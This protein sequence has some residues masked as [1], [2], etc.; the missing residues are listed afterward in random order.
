M[1]AL[2]HFVSIIFHP[3]LL[4]TY[5][6]WVLGWFFPGLL[7]VNREVLLPVSGFVFLVT[8]ILPALNL[9]MFRYFGTIT[10]YFLSDH[11]QRIIPFFFIALIY[12]LVTALFYFK[13]PLS[14][15]F[16][17]LMIIVTVMVV[18]SA[19]ITV[20]YKVSVHSLGIWGCVGMMLPLN[21]AVEDGAMLW[22]TCIAIIIAGLVMWA[23][24]LLNVHVPRQVL[25]G[26]LVGL[27]IGFAGMIS[28]F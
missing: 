24:L 18:A 28:L 16:I 2:A 9:L 3:L 19:I 13:L 12:M 22:P 11:R 1:T 25:V 15:N 27:A 21:K 7:M 26:S 10:S 8:G 6:V 23:R 17:K 5:M 20:F 4:S 14:D